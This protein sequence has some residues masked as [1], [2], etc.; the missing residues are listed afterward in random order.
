M[1]E[2]TPSLENPMYQRFPTLVQLGQQNANH[3][4][5]TWHNRPYDLFCYFE[6]YDE[7]GKPDIYRNMLFGLRTARPQ[8]TPRAVG[9]ASYLLQLQKNTV[10]ASSYQHFESPELVQ[11]T[12]DFDILNTGAR[13]H[14]ELGFLISPE[15]RG[16]HLGQVLFAS[17]LVV[18]ESLGIEHVSISGDQ[19]VDPETNSR[20]NTG[21]QWDDA[22]GMF[23]PTQRS[24]FYGRYNGM[25]RIRDIGQDPATPYYI[26]NMPTK[27]SLYQASL[28]ERASTDH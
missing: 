23:T 28:L 22:V 6:N 9:L 7:D 18:L 24:S 1:A 11:A 16:E 12:A 15:F 27:I 5:L 19:T 17:S 20:F 2:N 21:Y 8:E 26:T 14:K 4:R 10:E 3:V 13:G 25:H